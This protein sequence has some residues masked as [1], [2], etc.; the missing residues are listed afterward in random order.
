MTV[1][2]SVQN[3]N[4]NKIFRTAKLFSKKEIKPQTNNPL[5]F[6]NPPKLNSKNMKPKDKVY[7]LDDLNANSWAIFIPRNNSLEKIYEGTDLNTL[8]KGIGHFSETTKDKGNICL[9]GHNIGITV[10]PF[11]YIHK[12]EKSDKIYYRFN[13]KTYTYILEFKEEIE[14]TDFT[15][16]KNTKE[17]YLTIITCIV[18]KKDKRLVLRLKRI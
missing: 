15:Y 7:T 14:E 12:L 9:A 6:N 10:S 13:N 17:N 18:G 11:R 1:H 4:I 16:I 3:E 8:E 5:I 2:S